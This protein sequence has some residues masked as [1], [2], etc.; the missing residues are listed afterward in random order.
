MQEI[1]QQNLMRIQHYFHEVMGASSPPID[2]HNLKLPTLTITEETTWFP[3]PGIYGGFKYVGG[4]V[5]ETRQ[6]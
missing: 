3:I 4:M 2:K 1:P 6:S 5:K